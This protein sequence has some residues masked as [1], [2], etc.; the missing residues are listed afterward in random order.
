MF[1][2]VGAIATRVRARYVSGAS[3]DLKINLVHQKQ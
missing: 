2:R 3:A 1:G